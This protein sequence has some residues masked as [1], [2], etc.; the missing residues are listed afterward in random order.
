[1]EKRRIEYNKWLGDTTVVLKAET[2]EQALSHVRVAERDIFKE[3]NYVRYDN[4]EKKV[5][6][7]GFEKEFEI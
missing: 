6:I 3:I 4:R 7:M 5:T 2:L 1:M